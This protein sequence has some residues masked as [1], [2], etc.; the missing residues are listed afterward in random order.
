MASSLTGVDVGTFRKAQRAEG[1]AT[2]LAIGTATPSHCVYQADYPDYYFRITKSDHMVDLK[3]KFQRMCDNSMIRKRYMHVTE[4]FLKQ[5]PNMCEYMAPS[6]DAR[7]D[8]VVV[9]VPKLGKEAA[10]KAIKEWGYPKSK[11]THLV[12]CTTSG[13]DMPGADY[14]LT[15]LLGLRPSVQRFMLYQQ[16]CFAGGTVL[17]LAKDLAENNKGARVLVVC[18]E[19][20]AVTFRGPSESHLD[21]LVGQALFGD[22]AAAIVVG[23]DPDLDVERPLFEMV[24][25]A[26]TILPESEGAID[27]H[28]REA[29][30]TFH[31]LKDVPGL[32]ANNIEKALAHAF[33]PLGIDDWNTI[34][35]I[36]H[37]GGPAI[38]DQVELKLGLE[39]QKMRATRHVLSEY[40]NMSSACVLFILDEMRKKSTEE[41]KTTT[42][43]GLDWGV[44]FGFGPGLTVETV[45]LH[46]L[47]TTVPTSTT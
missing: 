7:Q 9:E 39:E 19:I 27:G 41:G 22:G 16:G 33:S 3:Q 15:K 31:L 38:L 14:Q 42:G 20:T 40:G 8:V 11:I 28:L 4:E 25:A 43:E 34:F 18:S 13:V 35:W 17:R 44:L 45:V 29:G 36:A 37:P 47:P 26:Q 24:S 23:S 10:I 1:P 6:L 12:F 46:S 2:I 5:N 30:L 32:I 21:S